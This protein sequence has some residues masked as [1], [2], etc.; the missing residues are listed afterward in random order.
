MTYYSL[1]IAFHIA[2]ALAHGVTTFA[3]LDE[4]FLRVDGITVY[5]C[6]LYSRF[7]IIR[8]FYYNT[9]D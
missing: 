4:D 7:S 2:T 6:L 5:T 8:D 9:Y 3:T 1:L